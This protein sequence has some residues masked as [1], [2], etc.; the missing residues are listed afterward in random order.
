MSVMESHPVDLQNIHPHTDNQQHTLREC[1]ETAV[2]DYFTQ[3]EGQ[4][5]TDLYNLFLAEVEAPLLQ[6]VMTHTRGNQ[7]QASV[8][9]GLNR[10]TLRKKLKSYDL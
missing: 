7:T 10:G 4:Q 2:E 9:L 8:L 5:V 3:L 1:V 6:A